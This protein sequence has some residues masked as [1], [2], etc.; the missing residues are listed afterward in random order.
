MSIRFDPNN[1]VL[2]LYMKPRSSVMPF[3][4][5]EKTGVF[6]KQETVQKPDGANGIAEG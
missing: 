2:R 1:A 5:K 6:M 4:M 3:S